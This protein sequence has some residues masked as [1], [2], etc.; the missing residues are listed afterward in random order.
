MQSKELALAA[1]R[2]LDERKAQD[3][4]VLDV[5]HLTIIAD[6]FVI[7]SGRSANQVRALSDDVDDKLSMLGEEPR[8]REGTSEGRWAVM[9]YGSVLVHIFHEQEREYYNLERLWTDGSNRV[10][11]E[12]T[13]D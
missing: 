10:E 5:Q 7:A 11:F 9:D 6:Y 4:I 1:A 2:E 8:R 3:I 13:E 12:Q